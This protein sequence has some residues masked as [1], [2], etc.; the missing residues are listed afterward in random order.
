VARVLRRA[1]G[2]ALLLFDPRAGVEALAEVRSV[3]GAR[4]QVEVGPVAQA[5][6][7]SREVILLQAVGK[8]DK[9]D[10]VVQDATELGATRI[11]PVLTERTVVQPGPRSAARVERWRRVADGAARQCGR[12]LAPV[13]EEIA[14]LVAAASSVE[15]ELRLALVPRAERAAGPLLLGETGSVAFLVGP[16]GGL[17]EAEVQALA[18]GGWLPAS[19]GPTT[20]RTETVATAVL[21]ALLVLGAPER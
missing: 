11:F 16:E 20:L 8:G 13:V 10:A 14:P 3:D 21:G 19:L 7:P 1:R 17:T 4:V 12:A 15:A 18:E 6:P 5:T 9:M 2:D